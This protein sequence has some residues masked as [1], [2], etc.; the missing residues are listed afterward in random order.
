MRNIVGGLKAALK[1]G[2]AIEAF[3]F[4]LGCPSLVEITLKASPDAIVIDLQHGLWTRDGLETVLRADVATIVRVRDG[5]STSIG[6]ALDAGAEAVLVPL[7]DNAAQAMACVSAAHYPPFG[8]RSGGGVR[9]L[10]GDFETYVN[11]A[12]ARTAV[13]VMIETEEGLRNAKEIVSIAD[14]DFVFIGSGDLALSL[15]CFPSGGERLERAF[16]EIR[17]ACEQANVPCGIFTGDAKEA[18]SRVSQGYA[19]VILAEDVGVVS[20]GF[21]DARKS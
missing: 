10:G 9:P 1:S 16:A 11:G 5:S 17:L 2:H 4:A 21:A 12:R 20:S 7:V 8:Q 13:G 19:I 6:E 3:W 15:G 18:A 14:L